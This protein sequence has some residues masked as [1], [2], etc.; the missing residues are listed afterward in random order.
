[1]WWNLLSLDA[2]T[3]VLLWSL[4]FA[5]EF[6]AAYPPW[7]FAVLAATVWIIYAG[8]RVLDA[9]RAPAATNR[10][11]RHDFHARHWSIVALA[12]LPITVGTGFIAFSRLDVQ[13]R[14]AGLAMCA[15]V[16]AYALVIHAAPRRL[17]RRFPKELAVGLIFAAG[18]VLPVWTHAPQSRNSLLLPAFAFAALCAVN[19]MAIES[20]EHPADITDGRQPNRLLL[21]ANG[22]IV[23]IAA[24]VALGIAVF[25]ILGAHNAGRR[26][27]LAACEISL[28]LIAALDWQRARLSPRALRVLA[29]AALLTPALFLWKALF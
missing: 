21:H 8:D 1:M 2:P 24:A 7:E 3:V 12:W 13:T 6:R 25:M 4:F 14:N 23:P 15:I 19:C 10:S 9:L 16:I 5:R 20:W 22:H 17:A 28:C 27:L 26:E 11:D 18:A 29:D